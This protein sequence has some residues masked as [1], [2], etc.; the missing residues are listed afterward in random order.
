[1]KLLVSWLRELGSYVTREFYYTMQDLLERHGWRHLEP[2]VLAQ[3]P[4]ACASV[5][6]ARFG[7]IPDVVLH[8]ECYDQFNAVS[9][10]LRALGCRLALFADDLHSLWGHEAMRP[11]RLRAFS[12]CDLVLASYGY[13]FDG[14]YPELAGRKEVRWIPHAASP[15]FA[16]PFNPDPLDAVLLSG[17]IGPLYPLRMR[18]KELQQQGRYRIARHEHPGYSEGY[19]Y[20]TD[21]RIG[22]GYARTI[23][24]YR[25]AF[26]DSLTFR[27]VVAKHFEIPATGA[28]LVAD[29]AVAEQLRAL[30]FIENTH[31][32]G[33]S[34]ENLEDHLQ[35][36]LD[37]RHRSEVD[38][39]RRL[40][41]ELVLGAHRTRDRAAQIDQLSSGLIVDRGI[42]SG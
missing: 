35:Y 33:V 22:A 34:G 11:G 8:W 32:V 23:H 12:E 42:A 13:A 41:Q 20:R 27:Y 15:D 37:P 18:M 28:L 36:V 17:F 30:G 26:T 31:Y 14:F 19:D 25:A 2:W 7:E 29:R 39:I 10:P 24:R 3:D 16:L 6:R 4:A 9:A 5:L 38:E 40:G 1:M 21:E